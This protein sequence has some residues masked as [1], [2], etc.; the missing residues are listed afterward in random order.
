MKAHKAF[1]LLLPIIGACSIR[2]HAP[3]D[4]TLAWETATRW[5]LAGSVQS[6]FQS[7]GNIVVLT[8]KDGG[9]YRTFSARVDEVLEVKDQCGK[10]CASLQISMD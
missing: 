8:T 4:H 3:E 7:H 10:P 5:I 6:I 2:P 1:V 9:T